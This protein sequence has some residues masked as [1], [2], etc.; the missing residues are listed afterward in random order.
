[1]EIDHGWHSG[2]GEERDPESTRE[3]QTHPTIRAPLV[4]LTRSLGAGTS[5]R[6]SLAEA[7]PTA[8]REAL[9]TLV[10]HDTQLSGGRPAEEGR[11]LAG[12][13]AVEGGPQVAR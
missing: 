10:M 13:M 2:E 9:P 12:R 8:S 6:A 3:C 4:Q 1:M 11:S 5:V 7:G